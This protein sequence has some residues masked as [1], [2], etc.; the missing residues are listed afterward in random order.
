[1]DKMLQPFKDKMIEL[2]NG[3]KESFTRE[4]GFAIQIVGQSPKLMECSQ[5]S[6]AK[7]IYNVAL[8]GLS[9]NPLE[10]LAYL[11]PR[12]NGAKRC[13]ECVL[14]PSYIGLTKLA[15][16]GTRVNKLETRLVYEGDIFSVEY[17]P[18][19]RIIH[20]PKFKSK[21]IEYAYSVATLSTGEKQFEVIHIDELYDIRSLSDSWNAY[22]AGKVKS[23]IWKDFEGEMCRKT[24][25][26]RILKY[27]PKDKENR[28][29]NEAIRLDNED[30]MATHS[31]VA[32]VEGLLQT[33]TLD[34]NQKQAIEM[35]LGNITKEKA[36]E[37]IEMLKLNQLNQLTE[38]GM[39]TPTAI[40]A[41]LNS[42]LEE[43]RA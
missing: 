43:E 17:E 12:Y 20:N 36:N 37:V 30:Y 31:Q 4:I 40:E 8:S 5:E 7:S 26:K 13:M 38:Q 3:K 21:K 27:L 25:I 14:M 19:S 24:V 41:Q 10:K 6:I 9:L 28:Q 16:Q 39:A 15:T 32:Y 42:K 1:M 11:T 29:L 22:E 35:G 34:E 2:M 33:S 18:E 23:A